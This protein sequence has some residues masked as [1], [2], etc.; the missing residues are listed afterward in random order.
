MKKR[1]C[2]FRLSKVLVGVGAVV[3]VLCYAYLV[4]PVWGGLRNPQRHRTPPITPPWALE[5]WVWEDDAN[6]AEAALELLED[7][8]QLD[9][10]VRTVLIDSPWSTRYNDF[11]VD[12]KLFPDPEAFFK[13]LDDQGYRVVLWMTCMVN[14]ENKD[15]AYHDASA[16]FDA[17]KAKGRLA[18]R[19]GQT[20][21]WKGRGGFVD[22]TS[23]EAMAWWRGMQQQVFD[24][25]LDG[26]KLDGCATIFHSKFGPVPV[27]YG[28]SASG[29][30]TM[31]TYMDHYYRD[32]YRHG[33]TQNPEFITLARSLDSPY[34]Y[35]HI[36]GFAPLD[37]APV[38]WV[39]D[40]RHCWED[41]E[42]GLQRALWCILE[43]AERG[44]CV[45]GSDVA[46]YH[47]KEPIPPNVYI[48]WAQFSTF[49]GLFL[50][51]GHGE[52]RMSKRSEEER[53]IIRK[54][55]WLHTE[56]VPYMYSHVV[57]CHEGGKPLMRPLEK[58][59]F[60][61]L[62]G[63]DFLVA[64]I[65]EDSTS[66]TVTLPAGHWR[67]LFD[68]AE[69]MEGPVTFT[70]LFPLEEYP[71]YV[72]DGAI[73]PM[74]IEREYTGIGE[75]DWDEYL[76]LNVYPRGANSFTV[77]H[78]D[79][80]GATTVTVTAGE[81]LAITLEG[82][83]KPHILRVFAEREPRYVERDGQILPKGLDWYYRAEKNCLAVRTIE[84]EDGQYT[85]VW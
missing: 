69:V 83:H 4:Y 13:K 39:G 46:G 43:S 74:R 73:V 63:D 1:G 19:G 58:G 47:G 77:H 5:C 80:S 64:P 30:M 28:H 79:G 66:H 75:R 85:I 3:L 76:T 22:Y 48:R 49:C 14:S 62:F 57:A 50:N 11:A 36:R 10:P 59:K 84:Y 12:R 33:L 2:L 8:K 70:R 35:A 41:E 54:F 6:T 42:R 24:W 44:Y 26:W 9:F 25:G 15:T 65:Y 23:Q 32:E 52:R 81:P 34:P 7:Y 61:Y 71:V 40:N 17:A 82:V 31:R 78:T 68:D 20:R 56:L 55:S 60:H 21:W 37:A 29:W 51:G 67:Y 38:T 18:C 72:R 27:P 45:I 16:W 53:Q